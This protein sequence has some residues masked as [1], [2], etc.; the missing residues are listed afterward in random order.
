MEP[1]RVSLREDEFEVRDSLRRAYALD[2]PVEF[3]GRLVRVWWAHRR[4]HDNGSITYEFV[5]RA[6][7]PA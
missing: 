6:E 5:V 2:A 1:A 4:R 3:R 7:E